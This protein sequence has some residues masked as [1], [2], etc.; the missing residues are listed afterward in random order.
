M[1]GQA[2]ALDAMVKTAINDWGN[3]GDLKAGSG[4]GTHPPRRASDVL[5]MLP[6]ESTPPCGPDPCPV[7]LASAALLESQ[8]NINVTVCTIARL[9]PSS[10]GAAPLA[11]AHNKIVNVM[12]TVL[13]TQVALCRFEWHYSD[14]SPCSGNCPGNQFRTA[15][16]HLAHTD[17]KR[18]DA[19]CSRETK[20]P[21]E[22]FCQPPIYTYAW[23][24]PNK[25]ELT[26]GAQDRKPCAPTHSPASNLLLSSLVAGERTAPAVCMR[27]GTTKVNDTFCDAASKPDSVTR[28]C[29]NDVF[30]TIE[31][32]DGVEWLPE[33]CTCSQQQIRHVRCENCYGELLSLDVDCRTSVNQ[34]PQAIR[35][36]A[37]T[38]WVL[39][40]EW[41]TCGSHRCGTQRR[42][43]VCQRCTSSAVLPD[44]ECAARPRPADVT[45]RCNLVYE[46]DLEW[47]LDCPCNGAIS[48]TV[49]CKDVCANTILSSLAPC[50]HALQRP[51]TRKKCD[52]CPR[53]GKRG[54]C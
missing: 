15:T 14:W 38:H 28:R 9:Y 20:D 17:E 40:S 27:C 11:A 3:L 18:S 4:N 53:G 19:C 13:A 47:P 31:K 39:E 6:I 1:N 42:R 32:P 21:L 51:E 49:W 44:A 34:V 43:H 25:A 12:Q 33:R 24:S 5:A 10:I 22:R 35:Q 7:D 41:S 23:R 2:A 37:D 52:A 8:R 36:C 16:C 50:N 46:F 26:C 29:N 30:Y 45:Q 48:A 54:L